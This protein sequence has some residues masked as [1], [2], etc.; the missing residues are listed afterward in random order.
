MVLAEILQRDEKGISSPS[1]GT[2]KRSALSGEYPGSS[3]GSTA[4]SAQNSAGNVPVSYT[5]LLFSVY[6]EREGRAFSPCVHLH[7]ALFTVY[8][9]SEIRFQ[10]SAAYQ[11][12]V[13]IRLYQQFRSSCSVYRSAVLNTDSF[14]SC[15]IIDLCDALTD[16]LAYFLS[17]VSYTHLD[18][19]KRQIPT[20]ASSSFRLG[21]PE[22]S[23][24][25]LIDFSPRNCYR[26]S[27][28]QFPAWIAIY[29][30]SLFC[31]RV[32]VGR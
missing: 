9:F 2:E 3:S 12:A 21:E 31:K 27:V 23:M 19:Y 17:P 10:S 25:F 15:L 14:C 26:Y 4:A 20:C 6:K 11:A 22:A 18:V 1:G 16:A 7:D 28:Y 32:P 5:H 30:L 24:M 29:N 8:N 13:D